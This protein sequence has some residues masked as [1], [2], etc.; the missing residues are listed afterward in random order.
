MKMECDV[1][2]DL[3]PLYHDDVCNETSKKFVEEHL[4]DCPTCSAL[5]EKMKDST[6]DECIKKEREHVVGNHAQKVRRKYLIFGLSVAIITPIIVTFIVNL[7]T[8]YTLN[9]FFIVLTAIMVFASITLVPI[10]AEKDKEFW[11]LVSFTGSLL[12]LLFTIDTLY[13]RRSWFLIPASAILFG[14]SVMFMPY[15]LTKLPLTGFASRHK[16]FLSMVINTILLYTLIIVI[17]IHVQR[18]VSYWRPAILITSAC[19]LL[20]WMLFLTIRYLKS[21]G[22]I[23]AG[24]CFLYVSIFSF[25]IEGV[26]MWAID[27]V[28]YNQ[29]RYVNL[30]AWDEGI[31]VNAN[32]NLLIG[33]IG[34]VIGIIFLIAGNRRNKK[35]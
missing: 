22:L 28:W 13:G 35:H 1:V 9:W 6:I 11:A 16:G 5:L 2:T 3:L 20:A 7:A 14:I 24:L 18:G 31:V 34:C 33:V 32:V 10:I 19:S 23:K 29:L 15:I 30:L 8:A 25:V 17:G 4:E 26:V 27:G 12:L 21:N